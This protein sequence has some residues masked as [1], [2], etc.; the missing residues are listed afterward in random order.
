MSSKNRPDALAHLFEEC[1]ASHNNSRHFSKL[2]EGFLPTIQKLAS[3]YPSYWSDD[4]IQEGRL[5]LLKAVKNFPSSSQSEQFE[6]YATSIISRQMIDFYRQAIGKS[7]LERNINDL[8]G[9]LSVAQEDMDSLS[10][11]AQSRTDGENSSQHTEKFVIGS[12]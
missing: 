8:E 6:F 1:R 12:D 9:K 2:A 3:K 7:L 4:F 11:T 5:G 10:L